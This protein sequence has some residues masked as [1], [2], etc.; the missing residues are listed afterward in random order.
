MKKIAVTS[1]LV[2]L[3]GL[4]ACSTEKPGPAPLDTK[5]EQC[6]ACRMS[7][8]DRRFAAQVTAPGYEPRFFDDIG[9]LRHWLKEGKEPA[10]WTAW[11]SDH[12]TKSFV[13]ALTAV[14]TKSPTVQTPMNSGILAHAD[15]ASR[16]Q[17]PAVQGG[18]PLPA[19]EI[20][21]A[22]AGKGNR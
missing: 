2:L 6:A 4:L 12:R 14:Y 17:D 7:V 13:P 21:G 22:L 19:S 10:P 1:V 5:N 3:V 8:S 18:T 9:C 11:V 20:L 16:D 15:A